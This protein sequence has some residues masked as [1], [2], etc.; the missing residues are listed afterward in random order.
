VPYV[1]ADAAGQARLR[2]AYV[3]HTVAATAFAETKAA[4]L[5][6]RDDVP[7]TLLIHTMAINADAL[8][9][10]LTT[11]ESRG[12][13]FITLDEAMRDKAYATPDVYAGKWGPSWLFRW[14]RTIAPGSDFKADPDVPAWVTALYEAR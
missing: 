1:K 10:L 6:G 12:Y 14:S 9:A 7:Q 13:R 2:D 8:D 4:E 5:F 3:A 11:F